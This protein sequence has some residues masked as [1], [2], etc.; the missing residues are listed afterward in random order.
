[1]NN[2]KL[3]IVSIWKNKIKGADYAP[4]L[5][6]DGSPNPISLQNILVYTFFSPGLI[7]GVSKSTGNELWRVKLMALA[8]SDTKYFDGFIYAS[9]AKEIFCIDPRGDTIWS[10]RPYE[11]EGE[12]FYSSPNL[13]CGRL[14]FGDRYGFLHCLNCKTGKPIWKVQTGKGKKNEINANT[15]ILESLIY[16]PNIGGTVAAYNK[17]NGN[18]V[19]KTKVEK[20]I[21]TKP[22]IHLNKLLIISEKNI[23]FLSYKTGKIFKGKTMKGHNIKSVINTEDA[24][25]Y[26]DAKKE[27]SQSNSVDTL[28]KMK[29]GKFKIL[30][31]GNLFGYGLNYRNEKKLLLVSTF[32]SLKFFSL[33]N[34]TL[35]DEIALDKSIHGVTSPLWEKNRLYLSG[36]SGYTY[37]IKI[38]F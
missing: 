19:W 26:I 36:M 32:T 9:T 15:L 10:Y 23:Y 21:I 29:N 37:C 31:T 14:Y 33:E 13:D 25:V 38:S 28:V 18:A 20:G 27:K 5:H 4:S 24:L 2:T 1:M 3:R 35:V 11:G 30:A 34:D 17:E 12:F 6:M 22:I 7:V 8:N 16:A